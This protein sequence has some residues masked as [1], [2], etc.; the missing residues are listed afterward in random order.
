MIIERLM[1][2][3]VPR[4]KEGKKDIA[5]RMQLDNNEKDVL[6]RRLLVINT[7]ST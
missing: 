1:G 7:M 2:E 5:M 3:A 6:F 4:S